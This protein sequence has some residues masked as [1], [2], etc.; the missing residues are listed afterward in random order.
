MY[1]VYAWRPDERKSCNFSEFFRKT[2]SKHARRSFLNFFWINFFFFGGGKKVRG[3]PP[4]R[5]HTRGNTGFYFARLIIRACVVDCVGRSEAAVGGHGPVGGGLG[6]GSPATSQG[7][8]AACWYSKGT[9][10][11]ARTHAHTH[12][13]SYL[14]STAMAGLVGACCAVSLWCERVAI[15]PFK[16]RS[17]SAT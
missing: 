6:E 15:S 8:R 16:A 13:H 14:S 7:L 12:A 2:L 9:R 10:M 5:L 17:T 3:G 11:H 4:H 1:A